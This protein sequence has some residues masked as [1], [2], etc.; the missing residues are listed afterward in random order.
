MKKLKKFFDYE[1]NPVLFAVWS[2][3]FWIY[4]ALEGQG[5]VGPQKRRP[6]FKKKKS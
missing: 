4:Q 5:L 2:Y 6:S 3:S 1:S